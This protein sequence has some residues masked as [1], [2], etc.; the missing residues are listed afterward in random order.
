MT[1]IIWEKKIIFNSSYT[2]ACGG[3]TKKL[4]GGGRS[5]ANARA[6]PVAKASASN[7]SK[8]LIFVFKHT[9]GFQCGNLLLL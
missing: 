9:T 6:S 8:I 7:K 4:S 5:S 2:S 1:I 3:M